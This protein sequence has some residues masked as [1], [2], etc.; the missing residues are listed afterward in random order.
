M[1][2]KSSIQIALQNGLSDPFH[3]NGVKQGCVLSPTLF[4]IFI[5]YMGDI[6]NRA[7][8]PAQLFEEKI[9]YLMFADDA[10]LISESAERLQHAFN[11]IKECSDKWLLKINTEKTKVMIFNKLG[12]LL[13]DK[14]TLGNDPLQNVN[15]YMCLGLRFVPSGSFNQFKVSILC[16]ESLQKPCSN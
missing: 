3:N 13:K 1:Y 9:S 6:F 5:N 7:C 2:D 14:F 16:A 15:S 4:K 11:K 10:V 8:Q 12:R